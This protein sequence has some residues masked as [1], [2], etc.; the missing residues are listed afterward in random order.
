M[1]ERVN[2][3]MNGRSGSQSLFKCMDRDSVESYQGEEHLCLALR[4]NLCNNTSHIYSDFGFKNSKAG[5][6]MTMI[7]TWFSDCK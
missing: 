4:N 1:N 5:V 3:E 7:M 6:V 2:E